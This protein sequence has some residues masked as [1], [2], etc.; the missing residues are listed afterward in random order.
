[1]GLKYM[2]YGRLSLI[3][4]EWELRLKVRRRNGL[5]GNCDSLHCKNQKGKIIQTVSRFICYE[6]IYIW[7]MRERGRGGEWEWERKKKFIPGCKGGTY[8]KEIK[9]IQSSFHRFIYYFCFSFI[10]QWISCSCSLT[11]FLLVCPWF[12]HLTYPY[13]F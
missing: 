3:G 4:W 13:T 2:V 1:M 7:K 11:N 6:L 9:N 12:L 10:F 8:L 5:K